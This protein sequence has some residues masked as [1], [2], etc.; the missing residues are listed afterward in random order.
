[1][2][3]FDIYICQI[4]LGQICWCILGKKKPPPYCPSRP[5]ILLSDSFYQIQRT[6]QTSGRRPCSPLPYLNPSQHFE[7][8]LKIH[9]PK[10]IHTFTPTALNGHRRA[11]PGPGDLWLQE[12]RKPWVSPVEN[13]LFLLWRSPEVD[14]LCTRVQGVCGPSCPSS[15]YDPC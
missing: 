12:E 15:C 9:Q 6:S 5:S 11:L 14:E 7:T 2:S 3:Q 13:M 10:P 8:V 1:M 4:W